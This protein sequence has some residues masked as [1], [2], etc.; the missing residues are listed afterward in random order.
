MCMPP[1]LDR[2]SDRPGESAQLLGRGTT[3]RAPSKELAPHHRQR[4]RSIPPAKAR[5][6]STTGSP[7]RL[8]CQNSRVRALRSTSNRVKLPHRVQR[9]RLLAS[10]SGIAT[11]TPYAASLP[12]DV[13][14]TP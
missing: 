3:S 5:D 4:T 9:Q 7:A 14:A 11:R 8:T 12:A 10:G 1:T 6:S 13:R 2:G